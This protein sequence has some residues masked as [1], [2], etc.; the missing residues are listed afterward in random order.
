M[1]VGLGSNLQL[2]MGV[3]SFLK[4]DKFYGSTIPICRAM[5]KWAPTY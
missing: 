4:P 1:L 5:V 3:N 2:S